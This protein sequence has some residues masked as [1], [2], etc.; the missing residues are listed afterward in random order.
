MFKFLRRNKQQPEEPSNRPESEVTTDDQAVD[1]LEE[2]LRPLFETIKPTAPGEYVVPVTEVERLWSR[3]QQLGPNSEGTLPNEAFQHLSFTSDPFVKQIWRTFPRDENGNVSFHAFVGV[4]MWWKTA[5]LEEKLEGIFKLLNRSQPLDVPALRQII[6]K[7]D[8]SVDE[9]TAKSKAELL[10]KTLDD[11]EQGYI[12][13]DQWVKWVLQLPEDEITKLTKFD[14]IPAE[15]DSQPPSS[16]RAR[17]E[18][19]SEISDELLVDMAGRIG[20]RDWTPLARELGFTKQEIRDVKKK[21]PH[22]L[23]EQVYQVLLLWRQKTGQEATVAA[24]ELS[25]SNSGIETRSGLS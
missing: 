19:E 4:L 12:D 6:M 3:F 17:P 25:L 23:R 18:N 10:V 13:V 2:V 1:H 7:L 20:E 11:K 5:P 15:M 21:Y 16:R 22:R 14:I 9:E 8:S 24:L